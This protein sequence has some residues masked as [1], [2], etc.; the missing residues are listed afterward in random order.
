[1][2]LEKSQKN[3]PPSGY[4]EYPPWQSN[5]FEH[6]GGT[7]RIIMSAQSEFHGYLSSVIR[8]CHFLHT[9]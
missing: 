7:M 6:E 4:N 8:W 1:M 9:G 5:Q 2:A 3:N